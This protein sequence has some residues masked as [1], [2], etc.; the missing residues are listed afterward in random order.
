[1]RNY[2]YVK[3]KVSDLYVNPEN[4]RYLNDVI[5]EVAAITAMFSV[6][7][8]DPIKEMINLSKDIIKEGLNPFE[9][10][11]VC[12]DEEINK[13]VVYDGNRRIT[14]IKLMTQYKGNEDIKHKISAVEDIY[15]LDCNINEIQCVLYD[16]PDDAKHYLYKIH[17]DINEGVGRKQWDYQAKMKAQAAAGNKS[18]TYSIVEFIKRN[19]KTDK[20][21]VDMMD[22]NRWISKLE[23]VI[24]FARFKEAYNIRFDD[25]NELVY[26]DTEEQ[27]VIMMSKLISDIIH[28]T[29]T[30]KFRFKAD[31]E[32]YIDS[33]ENE[34]KTQ[35]SENKNDINN[36][37][38]NYEHS[39][40]TN[41][42]DNS[43]SKTENKKSTNFDNTTAKNYNTSV[44]QPA[45][46]EPRKKAL[47]SPQKNEA[48]KLGKRYSVDD[49]SCLN[50]KGQQMLLE[51]ESLDLRAF[52]FATAALC[53]ALLEYIIK[54]WLES[55]N[56]GQAFNATSLASTYS[57]CV[58]KLLMKNIISKN[59]H[60]VL[61]AEVNN[62]NYIALLN[63]WIHSDTSACV[64][65][66]NLVS[67]W[68]NTRLLIEKYIDT[69]K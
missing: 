66:T 69:H 28:N 63:T 57:G 19:P 20:S 55:I 52:P 8:G 15:K 3:I 49:Y 59:E 31:F 46:G 22:N 40:N 21:L 36:N 30:G 4:Y 39:L 60:K 12:F 9:M 32:K 6:N 38:V 50:E 56:D 23:R 26:K 41:Q 54:I 11:I 18:R 14:C 48:L 64:S 35:I 17:N 7:G 62:Q 44:E 24:G 25:N 68:K 27:V 47:K 51:L 61:S 33:L 67:G 53:R 16:N 37:E 13:Y 65:E 1:M 10:P 42:S 43:N 58:N 29:A 45:T 5:D 34:F 2:S